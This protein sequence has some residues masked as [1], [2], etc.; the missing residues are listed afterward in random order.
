MYATTVATASEGTQEQAQNQSLHETS[1]RNKDPS[2]ASVVAFLQ[3]WD[4]TAQFQA[5]RADSTVGSTSEKRASKKNSVVVCNYSVDDSV[6]PRRIHFHSGFFHGAGIFLLEGGKILRL[7]MCDLSHPEE[8]FP[9]DFQVHPDKHH[10]LLE[11]VSETSLDGTWDFTEPALGSLRFADNTMSVRTGGP[12]PPEDPKPMEYM[13]DR[14][15]VPMR[16]TFVTPEGEAPG[17]F[18][19]LD[20]DTLRICL[21]RR[22]REA[23]TQFSEGSSFGTITAHRRPENDRELLGECVT[24]TGREDPMSLEYKTDVNTTPKHLT[25]YVPHAWCGS[26]EILEHDTLSMSMPGP[27]HPVARPNSVFCNVGRD[28]WCSTW[29]RQPKV[30]LG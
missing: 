14:T 7:H 12:C 20:S 4:T 10:V 16:I 26:Y 23:P 5:L 2:K 25:F 3:F 22:G 24:M 19:F 8:G 21:G 1:W 30:S 29:T 15:T 18:E 28:P 6:S 11:M 13:V 9:E 27:D 17:I